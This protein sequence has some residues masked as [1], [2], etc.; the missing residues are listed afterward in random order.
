MSTLRIT[1]LI[2]AIGTTV[3]LIALYTFE[4]IENQVTLP[5]LLTS[6]TFLAALT[7]WLGTIAAYCRDDINRNLDRHSADA[8]KRYADIC[9][10][11]LSYTDQRADDTRADVLRELARLTQRNGTNRL[12]LVD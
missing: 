1:M 11:M 3:A 8:A 12:S 6:T 2:S 9:T 10:K 4:I 7:L 5:R